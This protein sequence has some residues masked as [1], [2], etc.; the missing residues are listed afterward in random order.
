MPTAEQIEA[1]ARE[2]QAREETE[3][4]LVRLLIE[5]T[6]FWQHCEH[7]QCR[8]M[9]S[10]VETQTC[11]TKYAD[12]ILWWKRTYLVPYLRERLPALQRNA[13]A[14]LVGAQTEAAV[15]AKRDREAGQQARKQGKPMPRKRRRGRV[16]RHPLCTPPDFAATP[17]PPASGGGLGWGLY[18]TRSRGP[19]SSTQSSSSPA[20]P[21]SALPA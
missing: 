13:P 10:C 9:Q 2:H 11:R 3:R 21:S 6:K 16:P 15:A 7:R 5:A 8:R 19:S 20:A 1:A 4:K 17:P 14:S 18:S 12:V